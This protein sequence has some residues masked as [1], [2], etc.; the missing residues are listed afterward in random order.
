MHG[1]PGHTDSVHQFP[2]TGGV[3]YAAQEA[4]VLNQTIRD[5]IVFGA[6]FDEQR[7]HK[8][9]YQ[10]ALERDL[11]LFEAGDRTEVGEKG[12]TLRCAIQLFVRVLLT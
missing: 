8:V 10:C 5:N 11:L 6:P 1:L 12:V 7:Y 2:R 4:W 9:L 3:A